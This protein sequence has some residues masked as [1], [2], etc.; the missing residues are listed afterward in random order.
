MIN[1]TIKSIN[2]DNIKLEPFS[3]DLVNNNYLNWMNDKDISKFVT[4]AQGKTS[5]EDIYSFAKKMIESDSDYFF[6]IFYKKNNRHIGNVRLGPIDHERMISNFGILIGDQDFHGQGVGTEVMG[7]IKDF[8]FNYL[9]LNKLRFDV[10]KE[11]TAAMKLYA[12]SDFK[13]LGE[14]KK[15]FEKDGISLKLVEWT[16]SNPNN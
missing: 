10:V 4:K 12:K 5:L 14:S 3:L 13:C 7:L 2:G 9:K 15:N 1:L 16:M 6:A 8:S 11:N